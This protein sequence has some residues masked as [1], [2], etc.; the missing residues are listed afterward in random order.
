[1]ENFIE[2]LAVPAITLAVYAILYLYKK[3][4][5]GNEKFIKIIPALAGGLGLILGITAFYALPAVIAARNIAEASF[6][7]L[8]SGLAATGTHQ[9]FKQLL[10]KAKPVIDGVIKRIADTE[11]DGTEE[12]KAGDGN[13]DEN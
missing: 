3:A 8:A 7:G 10:A 13:G 1:M 6:I 2:I 11:S 12:N 4:V 5:K 9:T